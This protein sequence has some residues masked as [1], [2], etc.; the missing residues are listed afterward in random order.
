MKCYEGGS[1]AAAAAADGG[2]V[3]VRQAAYV[4]WYSTAWFCVMFCPRAAA[5]ARPS[6]PVVVQRQENRCDHC[7]PKRRRLARPDI[8]IIDRTYT[9]TAD[10]RFLRFLFGQL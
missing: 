1:A 4:N 2:G 6:R 10:G 3:H 9:T 5:A 8:I 7:R